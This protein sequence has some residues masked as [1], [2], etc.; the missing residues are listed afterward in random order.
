MIK[1]Q[2]KKI[3]KIFISILILILPLAAHTQ[4]EIESVS[5]SVNN[6]EVIEVQQLDLNTIIKIDGKIDETTW[7]NITPYELSL[8]HI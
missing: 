2:S 6:N 8:I 7:D 4:S 1:D 3:T 5:L